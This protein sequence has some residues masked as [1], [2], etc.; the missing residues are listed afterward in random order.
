MPLFQFCIRGSLWRLA[1]DCLSTRCLRRSPAEQQSCRRD[2]SRREP[3]A[4]AERHNRWL[5]LRSGTQ[6]CAPCFLRK[7]LPY[8]FHH[9]LFVNWYAR[10]LK[11]NGAYFFSRA[12]RMTL[13]I[14]FRGPSGPP[15]M[16]FRH[17]R[18]RLLH[19]C[20]ELPVSKGKNDAISASSYSDD[21]LSIRTSESEISP[22]FSLCTGKSIYF[23]Y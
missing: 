9:L 18:F 14:F 5:L 12:G 3:N 1:P 15:A 16:N 13:F 6:S 23:R 7:S 20:R 19:V 17:I 2:P 21:K 10:K 22:F 11:R 8:T 4:N